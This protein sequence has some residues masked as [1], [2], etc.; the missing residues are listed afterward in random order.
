[1]NGYNNI[2]YSPLRS[3]IKI[4]LGKKPVI[5]NSFD[6][7]FETYSNN[8]IKHLLKFAYSLKKIKVNKSEN[9]Y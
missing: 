6:T 7:I 2:D 5:D 3:T 8:K 1:M 9:I 4:I